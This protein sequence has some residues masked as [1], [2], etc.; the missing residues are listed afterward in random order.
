M[1]TLQNILDT[2][3]AFRKEWHRH[4][5]CLVP[6][7]VC[8]STGL[9]PDVVV[10][11]TKYLW[12][13]ESIN[14]FTTSILPLLR[15]GYSQIHLNNP[16]KRFAEMIHQQL[17]PRQVASL[18]IADDPG[19]LGSDL[20]GF[21]LVDQVISLTIL[22]ERASRTIDRCLLCLPNVRRLS[23]CFDE[24]LSSNS[25]DNLLNM[26]YY[27][28]T[29]LHIRCGSDRLDYYWYGNQQQRLVKNA[30]ITS[31][32]F[33][34]KYYPVGPPTQ[35]CSRGSPYFLISALTFLESLV[36][37]R[38][39]RLI[40]T[41]HFLESMSEVRRWEQILSQCV[42]LNRVTVEL[43]NGGD[44]SEK[45]KKM[46]Q[47]LRQFRPGMIYRIKTNFRFDRKFV[48]CFWEKSMISK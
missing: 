48:L 11:I 15:D 43:T 41:S 9:C 45:S 3:I 7:D 39:V 19:R 33:D 20:T 16:S 35:F 27:P 23:L 24:P 12:L 2:L 14:A 32:T 37:V 21:H 28:V 44:F 5:S 18:R 38:R 26:P 47:L 6:F 10:E 13:D 8:K 40:T 25:F 31:F 1:S 42:H 46:E 22:S 36:N 30:T 4:Q 29:H 17:D 34:L